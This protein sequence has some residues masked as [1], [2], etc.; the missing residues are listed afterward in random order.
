MKFIHYYVNANIFSLNQRQR[1]SELSKGWQFY[2]CKVKEIQFVNANF[3]SLCF[4]LRN[5]HY[6]AIT[7]R[8]VN[9]PQRHL[10]LYY[11]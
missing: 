3:S 9:S 8:I 2:L 11:E 7:C 5:I 10:L 6:L 1:H 4:P